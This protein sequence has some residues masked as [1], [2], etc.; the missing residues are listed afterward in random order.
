LL[1]SLLLVLLQRRQWKFPRFR[2]HRGRHEIRIGSL[3][4]AI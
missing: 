2:R 4:A 3:M 1:K